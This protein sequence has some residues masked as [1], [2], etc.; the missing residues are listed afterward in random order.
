MLA[1]I[2]TKAGDIEIAAD[3]QRIVPGVVRV[4]LGFLTVHLTPE[5][6]F[7]I[8]THAVMAARIAKDARE[9]EKRA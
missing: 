8:G 1:A 6:A 4:K 7:E 3:E 9:Q 2:K 5:E